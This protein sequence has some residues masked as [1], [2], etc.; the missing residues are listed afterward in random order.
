M[1]EHSMTVTLRAALES[2]D[3]ALRVRA[4]EEL[5]FRSESYMRAIELA[6]GGLLTKLDAESQEFRDIWALKTYAA[7]CATWM[8]DHIANLPKPGEKPDRTIN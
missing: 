1:A 8:A 6:L 7:D 5:M 2:E 3:L 4:V